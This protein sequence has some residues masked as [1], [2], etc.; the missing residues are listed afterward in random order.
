[1]INAK[2]A[3]KNR[4]QLAL[5]LITNNKFSMSIY[6]V[7]FEI[8]FKTGIEDIKR[9]VRDP[10]LVEST[11]PTSLS[12]LLKRRTDFI[13]KQG[14]TYTEN[15]LE[16]LGLWHI[17]GD[18]KT[19]SIPNKIEKAIPYMYT[20]IGMRTTDISN[21]LQMGTSKISICITKTHAEPYFIHQIK[22]YPFAFAKLIAPLAENER[23]PKKH[24]GYGQRDVIRLTGVGE[25]LILQT[26]QFFKKL[27]ITKEEYF[28]QFDADEFLSI[29]FHQITEKEKATQNLRENIFQDYT[30]KGK[31]LT[32]KQLAAKYG[33]S[34]QKIIYELKAYQHTL[35]NT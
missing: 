12:T 11:H 25:N 22:K 2:I 6:C 18:V 1:M 27:S 23:A 3:L 26:C 10:A 29:A 7:Y 35:K 15:L 34:R 33:T 31:K 19:N 14:G 16:Q 9:L 5:S 13:T 30:N 21:Q 24:N 20:N 32:E 28:A 4:E 8:P 17:P